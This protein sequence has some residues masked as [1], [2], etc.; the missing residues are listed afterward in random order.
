M[1]DYKKK[2]LDPRWQKKRLS[3]LQRDEFSCCRCGDT[4]Q[5]LHVHH[6]YYTYG[7][8]P[9]DYE[10]ELLETLCVIC[11]EEEGW[12]KAW[13]NDILKDVLKN[14]FTYHHLAQY[15]SGLHEPFDYD[16]EDRVRLASFVASVPEYLDKIKEEIDTIRPVAL[17]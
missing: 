10:D 12:D 4:E 5:T 15:I 3:I 6:K 14:G 13:F 11:H 1:S 2:F 8:E 17:F 16:K 9:W 7:V